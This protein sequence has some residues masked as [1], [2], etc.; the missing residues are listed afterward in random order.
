MRMQRDYYEIMGLPRTATLTQIKKRYRELA[1]KY[2]PD[3]HEDKALAQRA[4]VQIVEAYRTLSDPELRSRY[5]A[6]LVEPAAAQDRRARPTDENERKAKEARRLITDAQFAFARGKLDHA[7]MLCRWALNLDPRLGRPHAIL[8]DICRIHG[9]TDE[10]ISE[11]GE[12]IQLDPNDRYSRQKIEQLVRRE[13]VTA[14]RVEAPTSR[15][16]AAELLVGNMIGGAVAASILLMIGL[17]PG[18]PIRGLGTY[19]PALAEWSANLLFFLGADGFIVGLLLSLNGM[20]G[21]P[22]D[23][24]MA[25]PV[26]GSLRR[27]RS[28]PV[29]VAILLLSVVFFYAAAAFY[30]MIGAFQEHVSR[31]LVRVVI[32]VVAVV[33]VGALMYS[34]GRAGVLLCGGNVVFPAFVIGWYLGERLKP[35]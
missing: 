6:T 20:V 25:Q 3:V 15:A 14:R 23:E 34:P 30:L 5:D 16:K 2:H 26:S 31:S 7:A 22:G 35:R 17:F 13:F 28:L 9:R 21:H 12:A 1:R 27:P 10:A 33:A 24:L 18:T 29:G 4:F 11:Y 8:G 19:L 32:A